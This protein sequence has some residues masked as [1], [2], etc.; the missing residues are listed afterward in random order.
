MFGGCFENRTRVPD[1]NVHYR[2]QGFTVNYKK[3][4]KKKK[5]VYKTWPYLRYKFK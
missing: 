1:Q 3:L 2:D 4:S 5:F